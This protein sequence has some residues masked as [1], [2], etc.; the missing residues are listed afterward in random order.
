MKNTDQLGRY[1]SHDKQLTEEQRRQ[2]VTFVRKKKYRRERTLIN[3]IDEQINIPFFDGSLNAVW[4][5]SQLVEQ[6][7]L[8]WLAP[9]E[10]RVGPDRYAEA[11]LRYRYAPWKD[12]VLI[13]EIIKEEMKKTMSETL[14]LDKAIEAA[15]EIN[16]LTQLLLRRRKKNKPVESVL[17]ALNKLG[18]RR[19]TKQ[20]FSVHFDNEH[21]KFIVY[22]LHEET[23]LPKALQHAADEIICK[24][25]KTRLK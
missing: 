7:P 23:V 24:A 22:A 4:E 9:D 11:E 19:P 8:E 25:T 17:E 12:P 20:R 10:A 16:S 5:L 6:G 14:D 15:K 1:M 18:S 3:F 13:V 2:V 21:T